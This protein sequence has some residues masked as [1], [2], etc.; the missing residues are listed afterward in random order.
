MASSSDQ[1][2]RPTFVNSAAIRSGRPILRRSTSL[3][4]SC[5]TQAHG[6]EESQI[7]Q[8]DSSTTATSRVALSAGSIQRPK[9]LKNG[10]HPVVRVH[11]HMELLRRETV[12][13]GT[14]SPVSNQI[15]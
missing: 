8:T 13:F 10:L 1:T 9:R 4:S 5:R 14:A 12:L 3:K 15:R 6:H 11:V 2:A 7:I